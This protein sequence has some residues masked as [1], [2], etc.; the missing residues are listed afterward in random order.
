M[1]VQLFG[2][3]SG[4]HVNPAVTLAMLVTQKMG[5]IKA[6]LYAIAQVSRSIHENTLLLG[7]IVMPVQGLR[8]TSG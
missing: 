2:R 8:Y 5:P 7:M 4:G 6:A 1:S 3:I